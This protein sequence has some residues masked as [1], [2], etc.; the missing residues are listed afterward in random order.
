MDAPGIVVAFT[1]ATGNVL[2]PQICVFSVARREA[3]SVALLMCM[4]AE[5]VLGVS[6]VVTAV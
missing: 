4:A 1:V 5:R 6:V 3:V 2:V